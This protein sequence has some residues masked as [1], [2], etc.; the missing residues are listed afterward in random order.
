MKRYIFLTILILT[1][2]PLVYSYPLS[3]RNIP[4]K[5]VEYIVQQGDTL[6]NIAEEHRPNADPRKAVY[7]I[8]QRN[9]LEGHIQPGQVLEIQQ[10]EG[11]SQQ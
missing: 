1:L 3:S 8:K 4:T 6:W 7:E 5:T 10:G 2:I 9:G 11:G